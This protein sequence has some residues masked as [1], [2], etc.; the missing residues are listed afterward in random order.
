M[1][2]DQIFAFFKSDAGGDITPLDFQDGLA[3]LGPA[4][5]KTIT[6]DELSE[7][8]QELD[9]DGDQTIDIQVE[10]V[11]QFHSSKLGFNDAV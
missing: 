11:P 2:V 7:I 9:T 6:E 8:F 3:K 5:T 10:R 1:T 4:I